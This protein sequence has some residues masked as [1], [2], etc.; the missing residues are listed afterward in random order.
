M[1]QLR[2]EP[3][4]VARFDRVR[5]ALLSARSLRPQPARDDKVVKAWNGLAVTALAEA[6]IG[7][8][9]DGY[10]SA[11]MHCARRILDL[12]LVEG[13]LRRS[14][15]GG[16]VGDRVAILEDHD[17]PVTTVADLAPALGRSV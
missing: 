6:G 16:V 2:A 15:L 7:L 12:H 3:A 4:D 14:S 11:A 5:A 1:L 17:L 10:L 8:D 13:R 9:R